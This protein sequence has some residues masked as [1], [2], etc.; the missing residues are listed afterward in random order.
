M[1]ARLPFALRHRLRRLLAAAWRGATSTAEPG[2]RGRASRGRVASGLLTIGALFLGAQ[3][4][5]ARADEPA[6]LVLRN[7]RVH[8]QDAHR[9][10]ASALAV[11]G[12][13]I[14]AVG[15]DAEMAR[16]TGPATRTLDL[17]GKLVLPGLIDGHIH[18][19]SGATN[20]AKCSL[21]GVP[22]TLP[23]ITPII[24]KCLAE[25]PGG[26]DDWM[27]V[28]LLANVGFLATA[29]DLDAIEAKR[30]LLISDTDGHSLWTNSRGL[31]LAGVTRDTR[32]PPGGVVKRDGTGQPTGMF[33]DSA[34]E[35][36][37]AKV[38]PLPFAETTRLT[39]AALDQFA[40][41]G[42]TALTDA[43]VRAEEMAVW[44][45]L[46][47]TGR[48][49]LRVRAALLIEDPDTTDE[50]AVAR[51]VERARAGTPDPARL[52]ADEVKVFADGVIEYP[53]QTAALLTPYLD[54]EGHPTTNT[55]QL[56]FEPQHFNALVTQLDKAGLGVHI[57]AIGDR[58]TRAGL[59]AFAA[60][61]R[62]NGPFGP[63]TPVHQIAHLQLVDPD[64]FPRFAALGV[65]PNM[66]LDWAKREA[67]NTGPIEAYIGPARYAHLYPA[68]SLRDAGAR[69]SGG[70]DWP[71]SSYDP[72]KAMAHGITRTEV[73][74]GYGPLNTEEGL[75][76]DDMVAAYTINAAAA[77]GLDALIGSLEVG[78]RADFI[79][80][81]R[82]IFAIAPQTLPQTQV[83]AT[84]SDGVPIYEKK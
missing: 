41:R 25:R 19:I 73:G 64:D 24:R 44:Q 23:A 82:D 38:P 36:I 33:A 80:L 79:I 8:T 70:S 50:A 2:T 65:I 22:G 26:A 67:A 75:T 13:T 34:A 72:F 5:P 11:R 27:E 7:A 29:A 14:V 57:H 48:L 83:L 62:A 16:W 28:V 58:A 66:Q 77:M 3:A 61:R 1:P 35:L 69:V 10:V 6:D 37:Q 52:R 17:G 59:D 43:Y 9:A 40:A 60:A 51:L 21:E 74:T 53:A 81:D 20:A 15:T 56:Y 76:I 49:K 31:A 55:G 84:Y 68:R 39:A 18:P 47:R 30:P 12:N 42:L 54:R 78:K 32:D 46:Y 45:D 4:L 63:Q 71:V